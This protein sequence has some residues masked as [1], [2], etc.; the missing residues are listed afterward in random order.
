M[1]NINIS[2]V[3]INIDILSFENS[4]LNISIQNVGKSPLP[5]YF[6]SFKIIIDNNAINDMQPKLSLL[7]NTNLYVVS[8][9]CWNIVNKYD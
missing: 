3:K 9:H 8:N 6:Y 7:E 2:N 5:G 1:E 4:K